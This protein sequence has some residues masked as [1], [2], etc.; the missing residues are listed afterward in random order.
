[1]NATERLREAVNASDERIS[2]VERMCTQFNNERVIK[3]ILSTFLNA[4]NLL[5][6][7]GVARESMNGMLQGS[8]KVDMKLVFED[9]RVREVMKSFVDNSFS[10]SFVKGNGWITELDVPKRFFRFHHA[11]DGAK[12]F[13][14][15]DEMAL[16]LSIE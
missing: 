9:V 4:T 8:G 3:T 15:W 14:T 2:F 10:V 13:M 12:D 11:T 7:S 1:M 16:F 6:S 5:N